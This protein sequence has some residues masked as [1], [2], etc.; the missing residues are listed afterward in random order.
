MILELKLFLLLKFLLFVTYADAANNDGY[1]TDTHSKNYQAYIE[2]DCLYSFSE[3]AVVPVL[4]AFSTR[5]A[6]CATV[7]SAF[8]RLTL[9]CTCPALRKANTKIRL[10]TT[11]S[12]SFLTAI[13]RVLISLASIS[14]GYASVLCSAKT[15]FQKQYYA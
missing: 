15:S 6:I 3:V 10:D 13:V 7:C 9:S 14:I 8:T 12:S 2:S 5:T 4:H 11:Y 1:T